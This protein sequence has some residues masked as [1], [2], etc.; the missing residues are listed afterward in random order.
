MLRWCKW[1]TD[2]VPAALENAQWLI[3]GHAA[4]EIDDDQEDGLGLGVLRAWFSD[5]PVAVVLKVR[6]SLSINC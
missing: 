1:C 3:S 6:A 5:E 4:V 2:G